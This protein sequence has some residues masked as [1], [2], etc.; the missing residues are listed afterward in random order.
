M[1]EIILS[2]KDF[3]DGNYRSAD[4]EPGPLDF[5]GNVIIDGGLGLVR[6]SSLG[7]TGR[8]LVKEGTSLEVTVYSIVAGG[9][10]TVDGHIVTKESIVASQ[11]TAWGS[12]KAGRSI[13]TR[14]SIESKDGNI[15]AEVGHIRAHGYIKSNGFIKSGLGISATQS[16]TCKSLLKFSNHCF[17]GVC[18]WREITDDDKKITCGKLEGGT[19]LHGNVVETGTEE[20]ATLN[21]SGR[22]IEFDLDGTKHT[23]VIQ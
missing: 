7:L 5:D 14:G 9:S 4:I 18:S 22:T 21:L 1:H 6:F 3:N 16:I 17:A 2:K 23:A 10:I 8:L 13:E 20:A 11:I 19:V 12:I 15:E